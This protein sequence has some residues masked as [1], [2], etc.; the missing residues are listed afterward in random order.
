MNYRQTHLDKGGVY[1][2]TIAS[3]PFDAYMARWEAFYLRRI[4]PNLVHGG[5]RYLD[6][7][8]GTGRITS[9]VAPLVRES[10][11][12]DLSE[13][14]LA[15]ARSKC[16]GTR[17]LQ[18][19]LTREDVDIGE[20]DLA[21][22][23]RFFGNAEHDLRAAAIGAIA[24]RVR[25]GGFLIVNNHR[26]PRA[27]GSLIAGLGGGHH[28][29]D[30]TYRKFRRL[31]GDSGFRITDVRPIGFWIVRAKHRHSPSLAGNAASI[32]ERIFRQ[33]LWAPWAPDCVI[34]AQ[35]R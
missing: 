10:V 23:F 33:S 4:V 29:M 19:D 25:P 5:G 28:D 7:A 8:C 24:R 11:G 13:S 9:I 3:Q 22:S 16:P 35:K 15:E 12:V 14:M 31:L 26:N 20:F 6:F 34:V 2:A 30:L 32:A 1:D 18:A 17:F 21:T 27:L